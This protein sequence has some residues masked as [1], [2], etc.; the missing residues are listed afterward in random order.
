MED[1]TDSIK[2][3]KNS[4]KGVV[5][6]ELEYVFKDFWEFSKSK[7]YFDENTILMSVGQSIF[8][9]LDSSGY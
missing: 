1:D 4:D 8:T 9:S 5:V 3:T 6:S 7:L 2:P